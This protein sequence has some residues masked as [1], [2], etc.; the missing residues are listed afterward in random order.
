MLN[1]VNIAGVYVAPIAVYGV[2]AVPIALSARWVLWRTRLLD[3]FAYKSFVTFSLYV[4]AVSLLI[5]DL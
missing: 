2:V 5:L 1:E 4:I 3:L